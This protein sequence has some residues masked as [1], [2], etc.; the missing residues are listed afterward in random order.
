MCIGERER[1]GSSSGD[2]EAEQAEN[3]E[4]GLS[5]SSRSLNA[6]AVIFQNEFNNRLEFFGPQIAGISQITRLA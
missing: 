2:R 1:E 5:Y 4:I 3:I 6:S